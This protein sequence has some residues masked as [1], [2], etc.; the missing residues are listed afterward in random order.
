M[1]YDIF[2]T[3]SDDKPYCV[4]KKDED[5]EPIGKPLGCHAS[6]G[7]AEK[8]LAALYASENAGSKVAHKG[9]YAMKAT[10]EWELEVLGVPFGGPL[11]G[12]DLDG[13]FFS[14]KTNLMLKLG[15]RRPVLYNHGASPDNQKETFPEVIGEAEYV[16]VD[17]KGHWFRVVLDRGREYAKIMMDAARAGMARASSGAVNYLTR[18]VRKTGEVLVWPFSELSLI[19]KVPGVREPSNDYAVAYLKTAFEQAKLELPEAFTE[20]GEAKV[21]ATK[22]E[23][24]C[25]RMSIDPFY[26]VEARKITRAGG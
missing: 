1:P 8:Q 6:R 12:K 3:G 2:Q 24:G 22:G 9:W 7:G 23:C 4:H 10:G 16:R 26:L 13:E 5:G 17:E 25:Q 19:D 21:D 14:P 15:D 11:N 18:I 20:A